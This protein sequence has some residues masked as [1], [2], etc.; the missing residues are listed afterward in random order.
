M[1]EKK[2]TE[3]FKK[4]LC[5]LISV[6]P[7]KFLRP[8]FLLSPLKFLRL[9]FPLL[10]LAGLCSGCQNGGLLA[11]EEK[12]ILEQRFTMPESAVIDEQGQWIYVSNV[13]GYA[14]DD[15]GFVSRV[16]IDG[17]RVDERWLEGLHSPTGLS[18]SGDTLFLADFNALVEISLP[19]RRIVARYPAP[20]ANPGLNDVAIS[21]EGE[22]FVSA[23][24]SRSIY[25]LDDDGLQTW[26]QDD[27]LLEGAN[28]LFFWR[29]QLI[30]AGLRWSVFDVATR[31]RLEGVLEPRPGL[32]DVDGISADGCGGLFVTL[33]NDAR[34][35]QVNPQGIARPLIEVDGI[36]LH[37]RAGLLA[38]PFVPNGLSLIQ[39]NAAMCD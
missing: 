1:E 37:Y 36:D 12:F 13:N 29:E 35:W 10:V 14:E 23:S 11:L 17:T 4:V 5:S 15:N 24:G 9:L 34:L 27:Y 38:V 19:D 26:L 6:V 21:A 7:L 25:R 33:I 3:D 30:H 16:S 8:L 28:G 32:A 31:T 18:I 22:V 39:V 2:G 20:H